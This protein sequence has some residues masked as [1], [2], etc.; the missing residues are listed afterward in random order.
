MTWP[1]ISLV[2]P[3]YNHASFIE[4]TIQSVLDQNYPNLEYIIIDGHSTDDSVNIIKKYAPHLTYWVSEKDQG[5]TNAINKGLQRCSG[6]IFNWLNSDDVLLP[7][8]LQ[9]VAQAWKETQAHIITANCQMHEIAV[10]KFAWLNSHAP[11]NIKD[12]FPPG[13]IVIRQPSTFLDLDM[14]Q[15][16]GAFNENLHYT[17][18]WEYY[19]RIVYSLGS[20]LRSIKLDAPLSRAKFYE[21]TKTSQ[22]WNN[23]EDEIVE[24]VKLSLPKLH[25]VD[26]KT[27]N[28]YL[29]NREFHSRVRHALDNEKELSELTAFMLKN[30]S[31]LSERMF[32]GAMKKI[33]F[34]R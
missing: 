25:G 20:Q 24:T 9:L 16:L 33:I 19:Y 4:E 8:A 26:L 30:P 18:D 10:D 22:G 28:K 13:K 15:T 17:M 7:G 21:G 2:T 3:S 11:Q 23:F 12:F 27:A 5:Q 1:K 6:Q 29:K 32:W 34:K 14:V 31:F